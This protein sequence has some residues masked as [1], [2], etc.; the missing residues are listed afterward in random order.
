MSSDGSRV[1]YREKGELYELD[2]ATE[3]RSDLTANH[4]RGEASAGVQDAILGASEEGCDIGAADECDVY[5]VAK[6][7]LS[8]ANVEGKGPVAGEDNLY[9]S[10][11]GAADGIRRT[12]RR[13]QAKTNTAGSPT[14]TRKGP[15]A[16]TVGVS[17]A[18]M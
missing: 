12:L 6:G 3:T 13:F 8:G 4:P 11:D 1:F 7:V 5:F 9:V 10:G 18:S 16:V 14:L 2:L 17:N 15:A